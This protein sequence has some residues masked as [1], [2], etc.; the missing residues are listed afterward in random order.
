MASSTSSASKYLELNYL[1]D[2]YK[3]QEIVLEWQL[4]PFLYF[5]VLEISGGKTNTVNE[6][7]FSEKKNLTMVKNH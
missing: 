2:S 7:F 1:F 5:Q 4:W 3:A 6:V